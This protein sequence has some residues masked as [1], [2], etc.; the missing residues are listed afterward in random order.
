MKKIVVNMALIL[1]LAMCGGISNA[2]TLKGLVKKAKDKVSG[3]SSETNSNQNSNANNSQNQATNNAPI[4]KQKPVE[5]PFA[6][7]KDYGMTDEIHAKHLKQVVFSKTSIEYKRGKE[8][9]LTNTFN[10]GD[11]I[12]VMAYF[13]HSIKNQWLKDKIQMPDDF[14][15]FLNIWY[16]VNGQVVGKEGPNS[17]E[18]EYVGPYPYEI[19][20]WTCFCYPLLS[21]SKCENY[22]RDNIQLPFHSYAVPLLKQGD[23]K[24]KM[25]FSFEVHEDMISGNSY[26]G[27]LKKELKLLYQ[28]AEPMAV[29]E[30]TIKVNNIADVKKMLTKSGFIPVAGQNNPTLEKQIMNVYNANSSDSK[31]VKAIIYDSDW[32]VRRDDYGNIVGRYV[33]VK[34]VVTTSDP[35]YYEVWDKSAEQPYTGGGQYSSKIVLSNYTTPNYTISSSLF[36]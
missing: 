29:G 16:E 8:E 2:Q 14:R 7:V 32:S 34:V 33:G 30:M 20:D 36:K 28:P 21:L 10:L 4:I 26:S 15:T 17:F 9:Q 22:N 1:L 24:V 27:D 12:Y 11:E 3:E 5:D 6:P 31:A 23:N 18:K 35:N 13:E 25:F 19:G